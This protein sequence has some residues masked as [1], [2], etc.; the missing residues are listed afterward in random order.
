MWNHRRRRRWSVLAPIA[1]AGALAVGPAHAAD[2]YLGTV[3]AVTDGDTFD[4]KTDDVTLRIRLCGVDS[5]ER[6]QPGYGAA[7]GAL[8]N[9]IEGKLVHC[10]PVGQG[11]PCDGRS[12]TKSRNRVVA[13]CFVGDKDVATEMVKAKQ[14]CDWPHFSGGHY[15]ISRE[16]CIRQGH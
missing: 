3:I 14:A 13:Q 15:R 10:L 8:S 11:T 5:P 1:L 2:D 9:M 7:A 6:S 12:K 4:M 16:T